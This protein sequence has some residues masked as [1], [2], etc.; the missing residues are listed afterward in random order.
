M[1]ENSD[2]RGRRNNVIITFVGVNSNFKGCVWIMISKMLQSIWGWKLGGI[3]NLRD[4]NI[5]LG[6][7]FS[8]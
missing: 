4:L 5:N 8:L 6:D 7:V 2:V 3:K 1:I